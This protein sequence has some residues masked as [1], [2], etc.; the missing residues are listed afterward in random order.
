[1]IVPE[2]TGLQNT[3]ELLNSS[4]SAIVSNQADLAEVTKTLRKFGKAGALLQ[5]STG[6]PRT[7]PAKK[8]SIHGLQDRQSCSSG[9]AYYSCANGFKGCCSVDPCGKY[10]DGKY[11][12][13]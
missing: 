10:T 8:E 4:E 5:A 12:L 1:M 6:V 2:L 9:S 11:G 13:T 7:V 3:T